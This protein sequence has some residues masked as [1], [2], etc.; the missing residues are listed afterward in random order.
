MNAE[1]RFEDNM[2]R[3]RA[4]VGLDDAAANAYAV[5]ALAVATWR[6]AELVELKVFGLD[7]IDP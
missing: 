1:E 3:A 4:V 2:G 6:I 5:M 7:N